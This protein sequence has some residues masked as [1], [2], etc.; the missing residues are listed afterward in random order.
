MNDM[1]VIIGIDCA[2]GRP[3]PNKYIDDALRIL[4]IDTVLRRI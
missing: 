2:P 3:R 4:S 1:K